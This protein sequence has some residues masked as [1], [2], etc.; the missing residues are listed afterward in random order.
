MGVHTFMGRSHFHIPNPLE[1]F[2]LGQQQ[3]W[4]GEASLSLPGI[5]AAAA[6]SYSNSSSAASLIKGESASLKQVSLSEQKVQV[7]P[8]EM[9]LAL[10]GNLALFLL[11]NILTPSVLQGQ[12]WSAKRE[13]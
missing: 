3:S 1:S 11:M 4:G 7:T 12:G 13:H 2:C 9:H 10:P 8:A 5:Q 6:L